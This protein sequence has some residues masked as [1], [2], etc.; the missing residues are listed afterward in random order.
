VVSGIPLDV[1]IPW[2]RIN[3][4]SFSFLSPVPPWRR[5]VGASSCD[6]Q[7]ALKFLAARRCRSRDSQSAGCFMSK[8]LPH[9]VIIRGSRKRWRCSAC[10]AMFP[11]D[12]KLSV[13]QAFAAHVKAVH[14]QKP[15]VKGYTLIPSDASSPPPTEQA[16]SRE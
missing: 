13:S 14:Q 2:R 9:L 3:L 12:S 7:L 1:R 11:D 10:N 4:L 6:S 5:E 15:E 16:K 8:L